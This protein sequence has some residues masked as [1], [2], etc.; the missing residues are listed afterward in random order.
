M[1]KKKIYTTIRYRGQRLEPGE[2]EFDKDFINSHPDIFKPE[3]PLSAEVKQHESRLQETVDSLEEV[4]AQKDEEL[5]GANDEIARLKAE[6]EKSKK[7]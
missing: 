7:G 5:K 1:A 4:V 6:I 2:Y 3:V